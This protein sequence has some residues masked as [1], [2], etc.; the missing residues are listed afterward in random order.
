MFNIC[1]Y[2]IIAACIERAAA[3]RT[4]KKCVTHEVKACLAI[5][6]KLMSGSSLEGKAF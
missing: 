4:D 2:K 1:T 6:A 5:H 3:L